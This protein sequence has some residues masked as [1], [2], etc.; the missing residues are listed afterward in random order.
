MSPILTV[1]SVSTYTHVQS[2]THSVHYTAQHLSRNSSNLFLRFVFELGRF[3]GGCALKTLL[4]KYP[5]Q[6]ETAGRKIGRSRRP[7]NIL[8]SRAGTIRQQMSHNAYGYSCRMASLHSRLKP[9]RFTDLMTS[10]QLWSEIFCYPMNVAPRFY[11]H[12]IVTVVFKEVGAIIPKDDMVH[13][14]VT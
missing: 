5:P 9:C 2:R 4:L 8:I 6:M 3:H 1:A 7:R 11:S 14:T 12:G 13:H 10:C